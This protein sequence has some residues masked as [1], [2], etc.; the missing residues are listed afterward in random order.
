MHSRDY[1]DIIRTLNSTPGLRGHIPFI[2]CILV[3][4]T[5]ECEQ[6]EKKSRYTVKSMPLTKNRWRLLLSPATTWPQLFKRW[7]VLS[8]G[9]ISIQW[10]VRSVSL[11]LIHWIEIYPV[12]S[13]IQ[14]SNNRGLETRIA[15]SSCLPL[16]QRFGH[17]HSQI[18]RVLGIPFSYYCSVLGIPWYPPGMPKSLVFWSSPPNKCWISR[19]NRKRFRDG[20]R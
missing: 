1:C 2:Q 5:Q 3:G 11:I 13:A 12:D 19:E 16:S 17:P 14:L 10:I 20:F 18:P 15:G 8:S 6:I 9:Y 7:I 4:V